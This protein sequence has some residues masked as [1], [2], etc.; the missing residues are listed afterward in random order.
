MS[1]CNYC[2][3]RHMR[4]ET[5]KTG[6]TVHVISAPLPPRPGKDFSGF[7]NGKDVF[8]VP[9][10]QKL[11]TSTDAK[12]NHGKQWRMWAAELSDHCVC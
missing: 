6:A 7:P 3:V 11:D 12:G 9:A 8:V 4:L 10:G 1:T 5:E 2:L